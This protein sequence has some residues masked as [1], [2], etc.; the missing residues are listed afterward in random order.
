M[1]PKKDSDKGKAKRIPPP[2]SSPPP[3]RP[4]PKIPNIGDG[5]QKYAPIQHQSISCPHKLV[6]QTTLTDAR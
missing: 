1:G 6:E 5:K 2:S 4:L 3:P